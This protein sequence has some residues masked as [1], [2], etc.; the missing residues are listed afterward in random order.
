MIS[1]VC[2]MSPQVIVL[3]KEARPEENEEGI[4]LHMQ[5]SWKCMAIEITLWLG[6]GCSHVKMGD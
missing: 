5:N 2:G 1:A 6:W 4:T 3:S